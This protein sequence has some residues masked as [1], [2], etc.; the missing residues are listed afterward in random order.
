MAHLHVLVK[1]LVSAS[2]PASLPA[3]P[4]GLA[5]LPTALANAVMTDTP[6]IVLIFY[7]EAHTTPCK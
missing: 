3:G 4:D 2:L 7:E 1:G 6:L 5:V